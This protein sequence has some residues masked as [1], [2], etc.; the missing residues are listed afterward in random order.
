MLFYFIFRYTIYD[1]KLIV[2]IVNP[3]VVTF[4]NTLDV[5]FVNINSKCETNTNKKVAKNTIE[6]SS[7]ERNQYR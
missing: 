2:T 1:M 7:I 5:T 3:Y 4:V 6:Y